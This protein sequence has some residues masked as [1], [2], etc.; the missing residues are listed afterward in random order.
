[1]PLRVA[2]FEIDCLCGV[3]VAGARFAHGQ[4]VQCPSCS[5]P[6]YVFPES[7]LPTELL[8]SLAGGT[9]PDHPALRFQ[10]ATR[11]WLGPAAAGL[12]ALAIVGVVIASIVQRYRP[13]KTGNGA[14]MRLP[15]QEEFKQRLEAAKT[16]IAEGAYRTATNELDAAATLRSRFKFVSEDEDERTLRA[17]HRQV[18]LLADLSP[19]SVEEIMRHSLGQPDREWQSVFAERYL[20]KSLILD[21]RFFLDAAGRYHVDY[22]L[23]CA[24]LPGEWDLQSLALLHRLPLKTPQRLFIGFRLAEIARTTREGWAVRPQPDSG[25]LFTDESLLGGLSIPIDGQL[26]DVLQRQARW[27]ADN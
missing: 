14:T 26:R 18:A 16:A 22:Q 5:R 20:G 13:A 27:E 25:V 17:H 4:T 8:G 2:N 1:M 9:A 24:G 3:K 12:I 15:P 19:E 11:F 7:P 6:L 10:Q 21:A 23:D